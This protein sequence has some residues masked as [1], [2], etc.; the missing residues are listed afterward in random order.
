[1]PFFNTMGQCNPQAHYLLPVTAY[2]DKDRV[3]RLIEQESYFLLHAPRQAGKTTAAF[4][5][6]RELTSSGKYVAAVV[7][8]KA[9]AG[10]EDDVEAAEVALLNDW[11]QALQGQLPDEFQPPSWSGRTKGIL[12]SSALGEW[13]KSLPRPLVVFLDDADAMQD[14]PLISVLSQIRSAFTHRPESFPAAMAL[15]G[16]RELSDYQVSDG[17][18]HPVSFFNIIAAA[19]TMN[20]FSLQSIA[21]LYQ[22]HTSATGQAFCEEAAQRVYDLTHGQPQLVNAL[23][24]LAVE[25]IVPDKRLAITRDAIDLAKERLIA[26]PGPWL[27]WLIKLLSERRISQALKSLM[28]GKQLYEISI[29]DVLLATDLGLLRRERNGGFVISNQIYREVIVL[30]I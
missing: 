10:I 14:W 24:R 9:A 15:I 16:V 3:C 28:A 2:L 13:A 4:E 22:Q 8:M 11:R 19:L 25:E 1:M 26:R 7:S 18:P 27:D 17:V 12:I 30:T 21:E 23:A 5:L 6:A 20:E 29:E